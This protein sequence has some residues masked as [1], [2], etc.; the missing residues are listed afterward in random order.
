VNSP[1][2]ASQEYCFPSPNL[3][4]SIF[5]WKIKWNR[6]NLIYRLARSNPNIASNLMWSKVWYSKNSR[7]NRQDENIVE[8][9]PDGA[10]R[11]IN[12]KCSSVSLGYCEVKQV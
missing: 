12:Q 6:S 1:S 11:N 7:L 4:L 8:A 3:E 10:M 2:G 5:I 9:H